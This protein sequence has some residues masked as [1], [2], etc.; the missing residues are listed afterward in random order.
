MTE[1]NRERIGVWAD[2]VYLRQGKVAHV[3]VFGSYKP[4]VSYPSAQCGRSPNLFD[5]WYGTGSQ[6]EIDKARRMPLCI[7]CMD[8]SKGRTR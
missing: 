5:S 2:F 3:L 8:L 7:R 1:S 4:G 6:T